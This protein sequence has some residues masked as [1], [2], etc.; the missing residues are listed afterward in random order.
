MGDQHGAG[1]IQGRL[2]QPRV[3]R[4]FEFTA[5]VNEHGGDAER[6]IEVPHNAP[7]PETVPPLDPPT[8]PA[9]LADASG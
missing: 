1:Q 4:R 5:Q 6:T 7:R 2:P 9:P 3:G 8:V